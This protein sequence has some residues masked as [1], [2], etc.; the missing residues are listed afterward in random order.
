MIA[1]QQ[2]YLEG[3][4]NPV[5]DQ[6]NNLIALLHKPNRYSTPSL[7]QELMFTTFFVF[8]KRLLSFY[9]I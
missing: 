5:A 7:K 8:H 1:V 4:A 2:Q 9:E 6:M 3:L